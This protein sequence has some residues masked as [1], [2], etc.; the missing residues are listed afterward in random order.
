MTTANQ[1]RA[2][3]RR[4]PD[5][6]LPR[7]HRTQPVAQPRRGLIGLPLISGIAAIGGVLLIAVAVV[8]GNRAAPSAAPATQDAP[9]AGQFGGLPASGYVLGRADA[10]VT[11]DLYEDFQCPA[12]R[13]WGESV[14]PQL[15]VN[16]LASGKAKLV[17]HNFP[18]I[19]QE[20]MIAARAAHAAARQGQFWDLWH[21]LYANQGPENAGTITTAGITNLA[22]RLGMDAAKFG[23][24]MAS[25]GAGMAV[26]ASI[27]DAHRLN[28]ES[29]PTLIV[30]GNLLVGASYPELA[31]AIADAAPR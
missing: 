10:P 2:R 13:R 5:S 11:I 26:D 31:A 29:T 16:E 20:S 12:C 30:A 15:A 21:A 18:F 4:R 22:A 24:D 23:A 17:F 6:V 28:V 27:A 9:V 25:S 1:R 7:S 19:G 3:N 14:F 8:T